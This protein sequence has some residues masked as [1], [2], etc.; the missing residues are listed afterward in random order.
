MITIHDWPASLKWS[1]LDFRRRSGVL[2]SME[3]MSGSEQIVSGREGRVGFDMMFPDRRGTQ[4][5]VWRGLESALRDGVDAV[6]W[7][8]CDPDRLSNSSIG[9]TVGTV[10]WS[11]GYGWSEGYDWSKSPPFASVST[12][13]VEGDGEIYIDTTNWSS[14]LDVGSWIGFAGVFGAHLV[15]RISYS[16]ATA[17]CR[18]WPPL[19]RDVGSGTL[20]TLRPSLVLRLVPKSGS[21]GRDTMQTGMSASFV[22][23]PD[24]EVRQYGADW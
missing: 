20:V 23:L 11:E 21:W 7:Q 9:Y 1:R 16:G 24:Q 15:D 13:A 2:G 8:F 22:E 4:A 10:K 19:R 3:S 17:R 14:R 5:R 18:I 12:A 6:R